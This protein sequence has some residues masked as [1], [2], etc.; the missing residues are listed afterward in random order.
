MF[1]STVASITASL[2]TMMNKL[3]GH[4]ADQRRLSIKHVEIAQAHTDKS[5]AAL[6]EATAAD[7]V[8][9]KLAGILA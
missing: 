6:T 3:E 8:R 9:E 7:R 5:T 4:A 1:R 2:H